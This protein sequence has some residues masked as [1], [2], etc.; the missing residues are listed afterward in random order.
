[1]FRL[2][3]AKHAST[4][5]YEP[6]HFKVNQTFLRVKPVAKASAV[7]KWRTVSSLTGQSGS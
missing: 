7:A 6:E 3:H 4:Q 1:M 5:K 2:R